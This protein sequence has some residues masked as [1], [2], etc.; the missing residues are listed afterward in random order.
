MNILILGSTGFLGKKILH[1][2][3]ERNYSIYEASRYDFI[4]KDGLLSISDSLKKKLNQSNFII[5][6]IANTNFMNCEQENMQSIANVLIP[7]KISDYVNEQTYLIHISSDVFYENSSNNSDELSKVNSNNS[8][9]LQKETSEIFFKEKNSLILRTSFL[10]YN[11]RKI[12][13]L[14]HIYSSLE[15]NKKI[16]GWGNVISS[17][18]SIHHLVGLIHKIIDEKIN[19]YGIYNFGTLEP[20]SKYD[21]ILA[22]L[23]L[24]KRED[25]VSKIIHTNDLN[26][27]NIN[28]GMS[29]RKIKEKLGIRLPILNDVVLDGFKDINQL[30]NS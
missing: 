20:Y 25:L 19:I 2:L 1:V 4:S 17:S 16:E 3:R 21:Y 22:I 26:N 18:V 12:G 23:K 30:S 9:S 14:N 11:H 13:L 5:N 15:S 29:S 7:K 8:Y 27:R 28:S 24:F 6:C 10:G